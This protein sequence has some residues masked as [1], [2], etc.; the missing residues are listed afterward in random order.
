MQF[1]LRNRQRIR[2]RFETGSVFA[3]SGLAK[4]ALEFLQRDDLTVAFFLFLL[5]LP[6]PCVELLVG[7]APGFD[8]CEA[9]FILLA[10]CLENGIIGL[11][12]LS[13]AGTRRSRGRAARQILIAPTI[14]IP[15]YL[16][17]YAHLG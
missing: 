14:C 1:L 6:A 10:V 2:C 7:D 12:F 15:A 4:P 11:L 16:L 9:L 17:P 5:R 8:P 13:T 3:Y